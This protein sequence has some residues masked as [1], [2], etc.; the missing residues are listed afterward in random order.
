MKLPIKWIAVK[1]VTSTLLSLRARSLLAICVVASSGCVSLHITETSG[2]IQVVRHVGYV[3]IQTLPGASV[4]GSVSGVGLV[5]GPLGWSLGYTT[6]RWALLG[7]DCR[8][9]VWLPP[10]RADPAIVQ[11]LVGA[12]GACV[13]GI[14]GNRLVAQQMESL[15]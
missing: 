13:L 7:S 5:G 2:Q 6:Q 10:G 9:V 15:Q 4:T 1:P 12:A 11:S 8:V 14:D 3:H